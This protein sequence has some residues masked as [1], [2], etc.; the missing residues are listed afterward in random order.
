MAAVALRT[1]R[2][3]LCSVADKHLAFRDTEQL[4]LGKTLF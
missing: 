4:D 2:K 3:M 1:M